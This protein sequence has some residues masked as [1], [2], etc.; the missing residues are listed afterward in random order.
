MTHYQTTLRILR[1]LK[2]N[3]GQGL[4]FLVIR[5]YQLKDFCDSDWTCPETTSAFFLVIH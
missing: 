3:R 1:Y 2:A 5:H 4:F